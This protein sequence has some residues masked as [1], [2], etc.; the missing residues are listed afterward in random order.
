MG[1]FKY[2]RDTKDTKDGLITLQHFEMFFALNREVPSVLWEAIEVQKFY[3][4]RED[5]VD[6]KG[7][8]VKSPPMSSETV[9]GERPAKRPRRLVA[10]LANLAGASTSDVEMESLDDVSN[11]DS[12]INNRAALPPLSSDGTESNY[13]KLC[14]ANEMAVWIKN[15]ADIQHAEAK[16]L[17]KKKMLVGRNESGRPNQRT[18]KSSVHLELLR[19]LPPLRNQERKLRESA[20]EKSTSSEDEGD[21]DVTDNTWEDPRKKR[22]RRVELYKNV[23]Q[24]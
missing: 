22:K 4:S 3:A 7:E 16:E 2:I 23:Y 18:Q 5:Y 21:G 24:K 13:E 12:A 8:E 11:E 19:R 14:Q 9:D 20:R 15:L 1:I 10:Q 17:R 6:L